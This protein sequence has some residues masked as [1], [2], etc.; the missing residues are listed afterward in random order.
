MRQ[1]KTS[2]IRLK[3]R[4]LRSSLI[5]PLFTSLST[6][7]FLLR[8]QIETLTL[9]RPPRTFSPSIP[10][11]ALYLARTHTHTHTPLFFRHLNFPCQHSC[12]RDHAD[13]SRS[14]RV[15][16]RAIMKLYSAQRKASVGFKTSPHLT[17]PAGQHQTSDQERA[18][19]RPEPTDRPTP[20]PLPCPRPTPGSSE[21][22]SPPGWEE[23]QPGFGRGR[24]SWQGVPSRAP[25]T[26]VQGPANPLP[27]PLSSR[28]GSPLPKSRPRPLI[29]TSPL[30]PP[31]TAP[32]LPSC[33][34]EGDQPPP[35]RARPTLRRHQRAPRGLQ[36]WLS[37]QP[38]LL[39]GPLHFR[40]CQRTTPL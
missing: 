38:L 7:L 15:L 20:G 29:A 30:P 25:P 26:R 11:S 9:K 31:P 4:S 16:G 21:Q 17:F 12:T 19:R 36:P 40:R 28:R 2:K 1:A 18:G 27:P 33:S 23:T 32:S 34:A 39:K 8:T 14:P 13:K 6:P 10:F 37:S 24:V 35:L 22:L 5:W 3:R